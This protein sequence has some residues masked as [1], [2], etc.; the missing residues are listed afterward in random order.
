MFIQFWNGWFSDQ[1][2]MHFIYKDYYMAILVGVRVESNVYFKIELYSKWM[3]NEYIRR[4]G[5]SKLGSNK[6]FLTHSY[7]CIRIVRITGHDAI[8]IHFIFFLLSSMS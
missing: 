5:T 3:S 6:G 4:G 8:G 1:K 2:F 7:Q